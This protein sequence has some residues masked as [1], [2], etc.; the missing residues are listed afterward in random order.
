MIR[1]A[2][3]ISLNINTEDLNHGAM[4]H[5]WAFQTYLRTRLNIRSEII[6]YTT[7]RAFGTDL[8]N[9]VWCHLKNKKIKP[10]L[11]A[12]LGA[13]SYKRRYMKFAS[14][15]KNNMI[16]SRE[17][18]SQET[19]ARAKLDYD[20]LFCESDVIWDPV[21]F[22]GKFDPAFFLALPSMCAAKRIA[23]SP[24]MGNLKITPEEEVEFKKLLACL[25]AV[26]C[27][28]TYATEYINQK[29]NRKAVTVVDPVLLLNAVD[30]RP[31]TGERMITEPYLL[32]YTPVG[33]DIGLIKRAK[34][35][36]AEKG[37][38]LIEVSRYSWNSFS[39]K[40][41]A[42]AGIEEFLSL[43]FYANCVFTNSF[44]GICISVLFQKDFY[45][46]PRTTGRKI[47]DICGRLDLSDRYI[48]G[49]FKELKPIDYAT[50]F[51]K[52]AKMREISRDYIVTA[53]G[54]T[55]LS[56]E[57]GKQEWENT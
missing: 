36:A 57:H 53:L 45:A 38:R 25:D 6:D 33:Y 49:D 7:P 39:H 52:L 10:A 13:S 1:K 29:C 12:A 44:H 51:E 31:V 55:K 5:S 17:K 20:V 8:A 43:L 24:S 35:F 30:F 16:V 2:G 41:I 37:L 40:T 28:E 22:Q 9:P 56:T 15:I 46:F 42:D 47:E 32:L 23:Y 19:L 4:L 27:R 26:S 34:R 14:F 21:F 48:Q 18:Y 50:V 3:I 11:V 54:S